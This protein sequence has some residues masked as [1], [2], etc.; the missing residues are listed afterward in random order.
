MEIVLKEITSIGDSVTNK[1]LY[2]TSPITSSSSSSSPPPTLT[3]PH[4]CPG[5]H[6]SL[7]L[8]VQP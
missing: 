1:V 3:R 6:R 4:K 5:K 7:G 8:I 2:K